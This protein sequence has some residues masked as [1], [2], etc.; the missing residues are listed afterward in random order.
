MFRKAYNL[1]TGDA[2]RHSAV[3]YL[4]VAEVLQQSVADLRQT[5]SFLAVYHQ[6]YDWHATQ[7]HSSHLWRHHTALT[8]DQIETTLCTHIARF[9]ETSGLWFSQTKKQRERQV[10]A[11]GVQTWFW[12]LAASEGSATP[13]PTSDVSS[14]D[15]ADDDDDR[16]L[17]G[18][19]SWSST[20]CGLLPSPSL[21]S[22]SSTD[23]ATDDGQ[24]L[25]RLVVVL[26]DFSLRSIG[27]SSVD[28]T[29]WWGV[30]VRLSDSISLKTR[31]N[32]IY[33]HTE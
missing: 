3:M 14:C 11:E 20:S 13:P 1:Y 5:Q 33:V 31:Q 15:A 32:R 6:T 23:T 10:L 27:C 30:S 2:E 16:L 21:R 25:T 18:E 26:V 8:P 9:S 19:W 28:I 7:A 29:T 24:Q 4:V 17:A 22:L 12:D